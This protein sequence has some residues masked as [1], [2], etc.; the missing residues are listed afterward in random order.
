MKLFTSLTSPFGR[1]CRMVAHVAGITGRVEVVDVD[2]K[3]QSYL[4]TNP[5]GKV[6]ALQ[7]DDGTV[8]IDSPVICQ[9]LSS[10]VDGQKIYPVK[11]EQRWRQ[12]CLEALADGISDAGI[13]IFMENKR[14]ED[15]R[16][17]EWMEAQAKKIH[18]GLD[19][20]ELV[21]AEFGDSTSIGVLAC[22]A[23]ISWLEFRE[24]VSGIRTARPNLSAWLDDVS[25]RD[26]MIATAPPADA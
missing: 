14:H 25:L 6:P 1:K 4:K 21:A 12:L 10:L 24:I 20:V 5:L 7:R 16:S 18:A 19:A 8:L 23:A 22:A 17:Q 9:Y 26:Y 13:L 15:K 11:Q 3:A 2:Y